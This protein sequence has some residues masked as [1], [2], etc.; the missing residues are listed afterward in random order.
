MLRASRPVGDAFPVG[1]A[2]N[3]FNECNRV[4]VDLVCQ[5]QWRQEMS[6]HV[7]ELALA[8]WI[9]GADDS[10]K[11]FTH[12]HARLTRLTRLSPRCFSS[13]S[14]HRISAPPPSHAH[15]PVQPGL[16]EHDSPCGMPL[17]VVLKSLSPQLQCIPSIAQVCIAFAEQYLA[18]YLH[19]RC[20]A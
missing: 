5:K 4:T 13:L 10:P 6:A 7:S 14:P 3:E 1:D 20:E 8:C 19:R 16:E 11:N 18:A 15:L 17:P 9:F 2:R 12:T